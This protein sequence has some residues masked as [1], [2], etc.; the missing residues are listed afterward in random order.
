MQASYSPQNIGHFGLAYEAY[1]H[2]TSPIRRYPDLLVHRGIR[3]CLLQKKK[4]SNHK[5]A[6]EK[7]NFPPQSA[8]YDIP[9]M[10]ELAEH[11]SATERRA[12]EAT[13]E[14]INWLKCYY[15]QNKLGQVFEG[16][17][18][19]V[20]GFGVF[21]ELKNIYVEGLLHITELKDDY[22][23]HDAVHHL[24]RGKRTGAVYRLGDSIQVKIVKANP[25]ER[26]LDFALPE[27]CS[28]KENKIKTRQAKSKCH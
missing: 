28:I 16:I 8:F 3:Y 14:A 25:E 24:L 2:F 15:M 5:L 12:D 22:Y 23:H 19:G 4:T 21:I 9:K 10:N 6:L 26:E 7:K 27:K 20:T 1:L 17:I 11:C 13:R 18:T